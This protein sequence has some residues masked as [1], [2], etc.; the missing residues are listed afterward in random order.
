MEFLDPKKQKQHLIRLFIGY[1]LVATALV[2]TT[3]ILLYQA[4]GFGLKN[5]QV[6]QNGLI[7]VSS[8]P[9]PADIY[10]NGKR[11]DE[12]TNTRLLL[13]AGQYTFQLQREG[14]REWKRAIT[15]E[16]GS[17]A[18]FDYPALFPTKLESD[19]RK[20]YAAKP[21]LSAQSLDQRW[22]MVQQGSFNSFDL[23]DLR[24]REKDPTPLVIPQ[25]LF[26]LTDGTHS[27]E[28]A[29]WASDNKHALLKHMVTVA[30]VQRA[31]Y[32]LVDREDA[33]KSV[34]VTRTLG[35][36]LTVIEL[37]DK[38]F[39]KFVAYNAESKTLSTATLDEPTLQ[40]LLADVLAFKTHGDDVV[41]YAT[42]K[43]ADPGKV[44]VKL[45]EGD[46]TYDIR[47]VAA[48]SRYML[49]LA[50][51]E[52]AWYVVA[53]APS[54]NR[55]YVYRDPAHM[56]RSK[57]DSP[58][59]PVQVLKV[60]DTQYIEFSDNARFTMA[61]N[62]QQFAVYDAETDRGY[63]YT[64]KAPLDAPQRHATWMDGH[65][66][67]YVSGGKTYVADFDEANRE[68]LVA[69]DP[70]F[71]PAFDRTYEY[72]YTLAVQQVKA[73]DG[74]DTAQYVLQSTSLRTD[75]DR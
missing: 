46:R 50:R 27:W 6:I 16:G 62:G 49:D 38:K 18:R 57:P 22:L 15:I 21:L 55:T 61:Q 40:P 43:G 66:L 31:E 20:R 14:Y 33:A 60:A 36:G 9:N 7:F 45:L 54:E 1:A 12:T 47:Q 58:L 68:V 34:N 2:L 56:V 26:S 10:V 29:E 64:A 74:T 63:R 51:Y 73:A 37:L 42:A 3:V 5:G 4:Y 24:D 53:G 17:V 48:G 30:G 39:D 71:I 11:H 52:N 67:L 41:L 75:R 19:V 69:A 8:R 13:P 59:V 65:R 70:S 44:S 25:Q 35:D 28:L 23:F 32:I 72:L